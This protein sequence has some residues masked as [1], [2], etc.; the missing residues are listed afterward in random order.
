MSHDA[1]TIESASLRPE[2][3]ASIVREVLARL[4][5]ES[6]PVIADR[7]VTVATIEQLPSATREVAIAVNALVTPAAADEAKQRGITMV[8]RTANESQTASQVNVHRGPRTPPDVSTGEPHGEVTIVD[9][10]RTERAEGI[11]AQLTRRG[12]AVSAGP[13]I[14]LS[15]HPAKTVHQETVAGRRAAMV[16]RYS[17]VDRFANELR[18]NC[19]VLDMIDLNP[20]AA[21]NTAQRILQRGSGAR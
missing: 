2:L 6:V 3:L 15:D 19:W 14:V 7:V 10:E 17:D 20:I 18:P 8:R 9:G 16:R 13:R 12:I 11:I 5:G 21:V 1:T 4:N